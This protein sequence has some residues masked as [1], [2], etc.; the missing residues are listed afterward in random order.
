ML[1]S[2]F[3]EQEAAAQFPGCALNYARLQIDE[4]P[5]SVDEYAATMTVSFAAASAYAKVST[6]MCTVV[7]IMMYMSVVRGPS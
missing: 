5:M 4:V 1:H 2:T 7:S 3:A 6:A